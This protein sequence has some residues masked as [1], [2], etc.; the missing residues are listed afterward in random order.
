MLVREVLS[1][2][3]R[4]TQEIVTFVKRHMS[5]NSY[6]FLLL[7]TG[8]FLVFFDIYPIVPYAPAF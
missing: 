8:I 6:T 1:D 4:I 5:E 3:Y 2:R 7:G